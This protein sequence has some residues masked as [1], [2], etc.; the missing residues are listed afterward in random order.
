MVYFI[1]VVLIHIVIALFI[2]IV[3]WLIGMTF[4]LIDLVVIVHRRGSVVLQS[5]G[6]APVG[7]GLAVGCWLLRGLVAIVPAAGWPWPAWCGCDW[8][9]VDGL[10]ST[11]LHS[12]VTRLH[13]GLAAFPARACSPFA[14]GRVRSWFA[15]AL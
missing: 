12:L 13:G 1:G 7:G 2:I 6:G 10:W 9:L 4:M 3:V 15:L 14:A 5:P 8:H 11:P